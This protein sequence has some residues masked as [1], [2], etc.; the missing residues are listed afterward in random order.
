MR[1]T[2]HPDI[3]RHGMGDLTLQ[4]YLDLWSSGPSPLVRDEDIV[5]I[6]PSGRDVIHNHADAIDLNGI[7][8]WYGGVHLTPDNQ[9]RWNPQRQSIK[10]T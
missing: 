1:V 6:T 10:R 5:E 2:L 7:D 3:F 8:L 9:W 4:A